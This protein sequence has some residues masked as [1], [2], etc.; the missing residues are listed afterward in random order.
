[1]L[2]ELTKQKRLKCIAAF[3]DI[4]RGKAAPLD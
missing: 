3:Y 1:V 2:A 4:A